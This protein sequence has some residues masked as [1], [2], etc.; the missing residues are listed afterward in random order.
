[1]ALL[2]AGVSVKGRV[3]YNNPLANGQSY[4]VLFPSK[5]LGAVRYEGVWEVL[6]LNTPLNRYVQKSVI[7]LWVDSHLIAATLITNTTHRFSAVWR[8]DDISF[9]VHTT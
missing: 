2:F 1:M 4:I 7:E 5:P 3:R 8:Y 6:S 9:E